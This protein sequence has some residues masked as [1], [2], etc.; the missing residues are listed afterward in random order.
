MS[1]VLAC[2]EHGSYVSEAKYEVDGHWKGRGS[3]DAAKRS[4]LIREKLLQLS[5]PD[6]WFLAHSTYVYT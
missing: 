2:A 1:Y 5:P 3:H 6:V 4:R